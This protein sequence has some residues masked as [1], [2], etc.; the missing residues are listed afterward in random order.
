MFEGGGVRAGVAGAK[1]ILI[2]Y[3]TNDW[4]FKGTRVVNLSGAST[5]IGVQFEAAGDTC[6]GCDIEGW[7]IGLALS[8]SGLDSNDGVEVAGGYFENN[9][10][11]HILVGYSGTSNAK[12]RGVSIHGV[13]FNN[14]LGSSGTQVC[15]E[16]EQADGFS[17]TGNE[18]RNCEVYN[19]RALSDATN[20]GAD[21][22]LIAANNV[23]GSAPN[24]LLGT[25]ITLVDSG[26]LTQINSTA[27]CSQAVNPANCGSNANGSVVIPAGST[28]VTVN[29]TAVTAK[30][31]VLV[32]F[33][34]SL[35]SKLGVTCNTT[36]AAPFVSARTAGT[37]FNLAV[38]TA[39]STN[40]ACYSY[41]IL[42]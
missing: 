31:Q 41:T 3:A 42:N 5:N 4:T 22:G 32:I 9:S 27:N 19:I 20:Q 29:T 34:S 28:S 24:S 8:P 11:Y 40:P 14:T 26:Q 1:G 23:T 38:N 39:P 2:T 35:S 10:R 15:V 25:N 6:L 37:S 16:L 7:Q 13:Y 33:D 18:F 30:S 12:S 17:I 21:N 36:F